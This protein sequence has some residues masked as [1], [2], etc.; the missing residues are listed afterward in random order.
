MTVVV[1]RLHDRLLQV[2]SRNAV[3]TVDG[4]GDDQSDAFRS[5]ELLLASLGAC[6]VGTMLAA[7]QEKSIDV[8]DV[9]VELK[10]V[11]TLTPERVS[12][13]RMKMT[14]SG[15]FSDGDLDFL[16]T[17]AQSCKVHHSLHHGVETQ[18]EVTASPAVR[19]Q[20]R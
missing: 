19:S 17:A 9:A 1:E 10:P 20:A 11:V 5:V 7:A 8:A 12:R 14:L 2:R 4:T 16:K 18:L 15:T 13:I 3:T 6:M